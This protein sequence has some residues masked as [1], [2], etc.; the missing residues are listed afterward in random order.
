MPHNL[1]IYFV[2]GRRV[3][4]LFPPFVVLLLLFSFRNPVF[5]APLYVGLVRILFMN[6][7]RNRISTW[8]LATN[9][10]LVDLLVAFGLGGLPPQLGRRFRESYPQCLRSLI[11]ASSNVWYYQASTNVAFGEIGKKLLI[12]AFLTNGQCTR[13]RRFVHK[14]KKLSFTRT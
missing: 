2:V 9:V 5:A 4:I 12:V 8:I 1:L 14:A 3:Q 13:I 10:K 6:P 11:I 7:T